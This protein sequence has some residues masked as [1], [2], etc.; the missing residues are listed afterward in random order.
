MDELLREAFRE[1]AYHVNLDTLT[2]STIRIDLPL[3]AELATVVGT[4][5]WSFITAWN[6]QARRRPAQDNMAAQQALLTALKNQPA[7]SVYPAIGVGSGGW[8][9][10]SLFVVGADTTTMD[11]LARHHRQLAYV[12]GQ[13]GGA[14]LLRE[15][16]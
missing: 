6:P 11:A 8:S 15:L 13:A 3:P 12:H 16:E 2:W 10:P 5:P 14:A 7:V 9:E 1:T 4:R